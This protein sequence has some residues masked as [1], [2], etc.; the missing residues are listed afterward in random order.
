MNAGPF[1]CR[2]EHRGGKPLLLGN[3]D[4][5][6]PKEIQ[7]HLQ[8]SPRTQGQRIAEAVLLQSPQAGR[9]STATTSPA[10]SPVSQPGIRPVPTSPWRQTDMPYYQV[11]IRPPVRTAR[12]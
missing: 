8:F 6:P 2:D 1:C 4:R 7:P 9:C 10:A 5:K 3:G 11:R 12:A